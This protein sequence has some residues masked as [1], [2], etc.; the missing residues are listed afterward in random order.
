MASC[1]ST[2]ASSASPGRRCAVRV[3]SPASRVVLEKPLGRDLASAQLINEQVGAIFEERQI[4][5]IDHYLGKETVQN[6]IALRFGNALFEP[7]WTRAWV[8]DVQ[9]TL[10]EQ[11]GVE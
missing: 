7:L 10:A 2:A 1:M 5:R 6:L 4:F 9:I 8:R 11:V 3:S